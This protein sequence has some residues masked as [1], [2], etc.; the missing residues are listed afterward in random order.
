MFFKRIKRI[1]FKIRRCHYFNDLWMCYK[2]KCILCV[3]Q[4]KVNNIRHTVVVRFK[5]LFC[6]NFIS[7]IKKDLDNK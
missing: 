5:E 6:R 3:E 4:H 7:V 1:I 2:R